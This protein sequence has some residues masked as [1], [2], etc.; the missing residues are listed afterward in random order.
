MAPFPNADR[1]APISRQGGGE[2]ASSPCEDRSWISRL[3]H[4]SSHTTAQLEANSLGQDLAH[5]PELFSTWDLANTFNFWVVA[6]RTIPG[7]LDRVTTT[8]WSHAGMRP[9]SLRQFRPV[10]RLATRQQSVRYASWW[11]RRRDAAAEAQRV[12]VQKPLF[13]SR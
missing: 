1:S 6:T 8:I 3:F 12:H 11:P 7:S 9:H 10:I 5:C 13:N 2:G 4:Q